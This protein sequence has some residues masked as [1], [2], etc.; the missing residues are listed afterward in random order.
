MELETVPNTGGKTMS[1]T[2]C[3]DSNDGSGPEEFLGQ[4]PFFLSVNEA[5]QHEKPQIVISIADKYLLMTWQWP[6]F[7]R[8]GL[9]N[10]NK[11]T[12]PVGRSLMRLPMAVRVDW[13][14]VRVKVIIQSDYRLGRVLY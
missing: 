14:R 4:S 1:K 8:R 11:N 7:V 10:W 13:V 2:F 5:K 9:R 6:L 12:V 3:V